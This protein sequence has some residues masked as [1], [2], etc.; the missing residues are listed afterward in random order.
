MRSAARHKITISPH[1]RRPV[2]TVTG[3]AHDGDDLLHLRWIG[4]IA[5]ILVAGRA[6]GVESRH[7]RRRSTSTGAIEQQL[8]HD[9]SSRLRKRTRLSARVDARPARLTQAGYRFA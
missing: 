5:Q 7:R 3:G 2:R 9:P 4:R 8:G 1:S 6:T